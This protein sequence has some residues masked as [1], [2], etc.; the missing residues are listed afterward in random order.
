MSRNFISEQNL[1]DQ[2]LCDDTAAF[3]EL[4]RRYC[5]SLYTY[6][7]NKLDSPEDAKRIVRD[8]F[9][10]L[11]EQRHHLPVSFS[12]STHLYTEVRKAVVKMIN[13]K[14][15][16]EEASVNIEKQI[17]PGFAAI[18]LKRS[19]RPVQAVY[20]SKTVSNSPQPSRYGMDMPS[21]IKYPTVL[22]AKN[23]RNAFQQLANFW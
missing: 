21:W 3:E 23:L 17:I 16:D 2:L 11:W 9:I 15:L 14:L 1:I 10:S 20:P 4:Y 13:E 18:Q 12:V 7:I 22:N 8:L 19:A 6:C 5:T